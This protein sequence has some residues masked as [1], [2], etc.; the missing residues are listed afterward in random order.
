[1]DFS[2]AKYH[3][4]PSYMIKLHK[5]AAFDFIPEKLPT[6]FPPPMTGILNENPGLGIFD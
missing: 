1:M 4:N 5:K 3:F 6:I 2:Q